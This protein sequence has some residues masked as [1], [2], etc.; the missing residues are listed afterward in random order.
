MFK[1]IRSSIT[2][3]FLRDGSGNKIRS[4]LFINEPVNDLYD[5]AMNDAYSDEI[6]EL[7]SEIFGEDN[8]DA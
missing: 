3:K 8:E 1:F 7:F 6:D 5:V 4:D 2:G